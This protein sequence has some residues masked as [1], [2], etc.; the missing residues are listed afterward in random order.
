MKIARGEIA[1]GETIW[2]QVTGP[3]T[4]PVFVEL[5]EDSDASFTSWK[6]KDQVEITR[7][8]PPVKITSILCIGL[9]Y[10]YHV[11]AMDQPIPKFPVV[12]PKWINAPV[13]HNDPIQLPKNRLSE[14]VDFEGELVVVIGLAARDVSPERAMDYVLGFT[15]GNDI[16]ARDWQ[17]E[18][19]GGQWSRGKSF[20]TF[21]PIGPWLV[22]ADEFHSLAG[23]KLETSVN[24]KR[25]Q[26]ATLD[27]M[28]FSVP[29][30]ISF[31][32]RSTVLPAGTVIMTGT[33]NGTGGKQTPPSWLKPGDSVSVSIEGIGTLTN[34][35]EYEL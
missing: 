9:N 26:S 4:A 22:T 30:I 32:S 34:P 2:A 17:F 18:F 29:D 13:G 5:I 8:L 11:N 19:G 6:Q 15:C 16:S 28:I 27:E 12:I 1:S 7:F 3:E 25:Q 24:G 10:R 31:L 21:A 35:V 20:D 23:K 14:K 33:P